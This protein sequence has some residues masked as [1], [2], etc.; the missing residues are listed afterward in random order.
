MRVRLLFRRLDKNKFRFTEFTE[1]T[2]FLV[3]P[4]LVND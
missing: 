4:C 3:V 1:F 2:A